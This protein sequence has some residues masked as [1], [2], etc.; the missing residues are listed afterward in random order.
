MRSVHARAVRP[1]FSLRTSASGVPA[2]VFLAVYRLSKQVKILA[3]V[4]H[5]ASLRVRNEACVSPSWLFID[6]LFK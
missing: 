4:H 3:F 6:P 1:V 5:T 2:R